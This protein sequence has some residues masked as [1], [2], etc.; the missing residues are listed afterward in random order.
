M[1]YGCNRYLLINEVHVDPVLT[2]VQQYS[3][4]NMAMRGKHATEYS[5]ICTHDCYMSE[6]S[7]VEDEK[8]M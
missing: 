8:T 2:E 3:A 1:L 6:D 7:L 4:L 5:V